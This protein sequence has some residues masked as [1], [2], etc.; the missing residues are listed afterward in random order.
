MAYTAIRDG[1][2]LERVMTVC[3]QW[4]K[5]REYEFLPTL[6][7]FLSSLPARHLGHC[8]GSTTEC[9]SLWRGDFQFCR[10]YYLDPWADF[11]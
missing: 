5:S 4:L 3:P 9:R 7:T 8:G 2:E 10:Y 6:D 1:M 11:Y